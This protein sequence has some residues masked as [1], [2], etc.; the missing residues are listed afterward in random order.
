[1]AEIRVQPKRFIWPWILLGAGILAIV[2][3]FLF[4]FTHTRDSLSIANVVDAKV[5]NE[6]EYTSTVSEYI[7]FVNHDENKMGLDHAYTSA[8]LI[9]L[10]LAVE[11]IAAENGYKLGMDLNR[12]KEC[13]NKITNDP[14]E[15]THAD[16]IREAA[17]ILSISLYQLQQARYP[18]LAPEADELKRTAVSIN[19]TVL[20]LQQKETIKS[21]FTKA[22]TLLLKMNA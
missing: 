9:K 4:T 17:E 18:E 3:Y 12:A 21:F 1:M 2:I 7:R 8:A 5:V 19:P 15:T 22:A 11:A 6:N 20:A 16:D 10:T 13:A 14:L